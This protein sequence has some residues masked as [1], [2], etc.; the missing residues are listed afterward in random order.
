MEKKGKRGRRVVYDLY[1]EK[2]G[3]RATYLLGRHTHT[4]ADIWTRIKIH[5]HTQRKRERERERERSRKGEIRF[6]SGVSAS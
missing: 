2:L 6:S 3:R 4:R 5:I 1:M